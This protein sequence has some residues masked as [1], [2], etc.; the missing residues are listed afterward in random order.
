MYVTILSILIFLAFMVPL[1]YRRKVKL[2]EYGLVSTFFISLFIEMYGFPFTIL[3]V[4]RWFYGSTIEHPPSIIKFNLFGVYMGMDIPMTYAALLIS[5]GALLIVVGWVTIYNGVK[6]NMLVT[7]GIYAFSRHPQYLGFILIISG[8]F[9]GWP[10]LLTLT[11]SPI[12]IFKYIHTA[13]I[14]EKEVGNREQYY[15]Y[16]AK[17]PF[18]I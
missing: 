13:Y 17:V 7:H 6:R 9:I 5:I 12:L 10:T 18:L 11:M 15:R 8:W 4:Q 1:S 2:I 14:E 3:L 16:K